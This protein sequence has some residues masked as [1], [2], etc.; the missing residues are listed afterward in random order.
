MKNFRGMLLRPGEDGYDEARRVWNGSFDRRPALIARC[1]GAG[2][3]QAAVR[4]AR[5]HDLPIAVRG[6]GHSVQGHGV[7]DDGLMIDLSL[8]KAVT[9]DPAARTARAAAGLTWGEFD[10]ATQRCGLATTGGSVSS[11]GIAGVTLGGGFGHL[12]RRYGLS[13]DNLRGAD[14]VTADG[15][16]IHADPD[17]LWGLRG[18]GGNFGVV[19][20]LEYDLHPVGP[21]VLGGPIFWPLDQGARVLR[22]LREWALEA[23]D[24]LGVAIVASAAPPMPVIPPAL[25]GTPVFGLLPV[26][27]GD[28]AE[29]DRVLKPLRS[30]GSPI[31]DLIRPVP[32]RAVQTMLDLAA[33]PGTC[34][35]WRSLRLPDLPDAV[36]DLAASAPT[37]TSLLNGWVIGG[38][39]GRVPGDATALGPRPPGFEL[40]LIANWRAGEPDGRQWVRDGWERLRPSAAGQYAGFL[41]DEGPAGIRAAYGDRLA[42]LTALKD[43]WDPA[44]VFH[45]NANIPPSNGELR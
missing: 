27:C 3:V 40:R 33:S 7:R 42:R 37:P 14:L 32:Y 23:P 8:M 20:A 15:E 18:G 10:L 26:W 11:T 16:L 38:A 45:L 1:A 19:T 2:D 31:G 35:Y 39:A 30:L 28:L 43:R 25:Y 12:L 34:S 4:H 17:L 9:V 24:E 44:N 21:L 36:L 22:F 13:A 29:G 41:A 6:G 5:A